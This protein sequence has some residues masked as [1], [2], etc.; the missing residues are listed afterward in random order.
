MVWK[1]WRREKTLAPVRMLSPAALPIVHHY[2]DWA[3]KKKK[4]K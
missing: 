2:T 4:K 3:I 1:L